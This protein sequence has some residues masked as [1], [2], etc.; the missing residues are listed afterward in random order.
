MK[1][2]MLQLKRYNGLDVRPGEEVEMDEA[3]AR[4]WIGRRWADPAESGSGASEHD[5]GSGGL[6]DSA[7]GNDDQGPALDSLSKKELLKFAREK[8]I[9]I[10]DPKMSHADLVEFIGQALSEREEEESDETEKQSGSG[11]GE[12]EGKD[13]QVGTGQK[14]TD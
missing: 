13:E 1:I 3:R 6:F 4:E 8:G 7:E 11:E 9:E 10:S 14:K 5:E 2:T 12:A